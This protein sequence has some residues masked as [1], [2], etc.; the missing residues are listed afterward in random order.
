LWLE[1]CLF[2]KGAD[3]S[4]MQAKQAVAFNT[5][6]ATDSLTFY[7]AQFAA[8][9]WVADSILT[10]VV[11]TGAHVGPTLNPSKSSGPGGLDMAG[12][13][14]ADL[15]LANT[16]LGKLNLQGGRVAH[17][18]S[19][20][21]ATVDG[22]LAMAN[23]QVGVDLDMGQGTFQDVDL[24]NAQISGQLDWSGARFYQDVDLTGANVRGAL[25]LHAAS[26]WSDAK[27]IAHH[28]AIGVIP[29]LSHGWP[30]VL[31]IDGLTYRDIGEAGDNFVH[32]LDS[33]LRR[34]SDQPDEQ[35]PD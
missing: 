13:A 26:W 7:A 14:S 19:L 11:L 32:W 8:D 20:R 3:L 9:L 17:G 10:D 15:L 2:E 27:L 12:G 24:R 34:Y 1:R 33:K 35:L 25:D 30:A 4:W 23:L 31:E 28:A 16:Q 29:G 22:D 6:K 21:D 18:L 5:S